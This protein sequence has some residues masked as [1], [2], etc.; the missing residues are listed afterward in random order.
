M[1]SFIGPVHVIKH[2]FPV[3]FPEIYKNNNIKILFVERNVT[4]SF[5][6]GICKRQPKEKREGWQWGWRDDS[7]TK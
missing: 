4:G 3:S 7:Q 5:P 1:N 2:G 6:S